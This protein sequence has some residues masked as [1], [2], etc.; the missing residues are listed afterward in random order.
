MQSL[1]D[2]RE[3]GA[4]YHVRHR[5]RTSGAQIELRSYQDLTELQITTQEQRSTLGRIAPSR[6]IYARYRMGGG[7]SEFHNVGS[8]IFRPRDIPWEANTTGGPMVSLVCRFDESLDDLSNH[9]EWSPS[10]LEECLNLR[11]AEISRT[12]VNIERE[13]CAPGFA[14]EILMESLVTTLAVQVA[15][16]FEQPRAAKRGRKPILLGAVQL[17]EIDDY[18]EDLQGKPPQIADIAAL[19]RMTERRVTRAF[20]SATGQTIGRYI[21]SKQIIKASHLL[22]DSTLCL[23]EISFRL[24]FSSHSNF[25]TAF[26]AATGESPSAFRRRQ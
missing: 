10:L 7:T 1:D 22:A 18:L 3:P 20:K 12:L 15:R 19:C 8:L 23:K 13:L 5:A 16:H 21:A 4:P 2:L 11:S 26:R 17:R 25:T 6:P 14:T 24:G 9:I